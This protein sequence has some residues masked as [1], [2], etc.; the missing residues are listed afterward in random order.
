MKAPNDLRI[1]V[2]KFVVDKRACTTYCWHSAKHV[3]GFKHNR[4]T[5]VTIYAWLVGRY[6]VCQFERPKMSEGQ[7]EKLSDAVG[8]DGNNNGSTSM[9][10][11]TAPVF[12]Y[13]S[14]FDAVLCAHRE[15]KTVKKIMM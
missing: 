15:G 10:D 6:D 5:T 11:R 14:L 13:T 12:V 7:H 1:E 8:G 4:K 2:I 9:I 3:V